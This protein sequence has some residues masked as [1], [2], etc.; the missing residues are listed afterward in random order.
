ML[1]HWIFCTLHLHSWSFL[2]KHVHLKCSNF[3]RQFVQAWMRCE[4]R[5]NHIC[6]R[7]DNVT[8]I[9][10]FGC[11]NVMH[12]LRWNCTNQIERYWFSVS[13]AAWR[14]R[15]FASWW[16]SFLCAYHT[17]L[18]NIAAL[19]TWICWFVS[20]V[21]RYYFNFQNAFHFHLIILSY[22]KIS[23]EF[24]NRLPL[25]FKVRLNSKLHTVRLREQFNVFFFFSILES[26]SSPHHFRTSLFT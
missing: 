21:L 13:L 25:K 8:K 16:M 14:C 24:Y 11:G 19:P 22:C 3:H 6:H 15:L 1:S 26:D 4:F 10:I 7:E 9:T 12:K 20:M 18:P 17:G 23:S 5:M 2:K